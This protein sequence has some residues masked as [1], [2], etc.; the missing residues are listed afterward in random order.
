MAR[1]ISAR[2]AT[3]SAADRR[4]CAG[5]CRSIDFDLVMG[6]TDLT[7][8]AGKTCASRQ[9]F[10]S[11]RA[12]Q[13]AGPALRARS[14]CARMPGRMQ[15][16]AAR[17]ARCSW[18]GAA[19]GAGGTAEVSGIGRFDPPTVPLDA[20]GQG[21][22]YA[23]YGFAAQIAELS[24]D[25]DL[26]TVHLSRIVA[27]HDVGRAINPTLVEG[28]IHGGIAQGIGLA[29]MEEYLPR[30]DREPARLPDPDRRRHAG[31]RVASWWRTASRSAPTA[32]RAS[33][34][35]LWCRPR[36]RSS[37]RSATRPAR[38]ITRAPALPHRVLEAL[39][40]SAREP[41]RR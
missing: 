35:R 3:R 8:D 26:G 2:A 17:T 34:S 10:V 20:E 22:P 13:A 21:M 16:C 23:T 9:T 1:S 18:T 32:P 36:R 27:A 6:D 37:R 28:Q 25:M 19:A 15:G 14:C 31:D 29:L 30:P 38:R 39:R 24:V 33:A 12:A 41:I 40:S 11:G 5:R 7:A 4:R